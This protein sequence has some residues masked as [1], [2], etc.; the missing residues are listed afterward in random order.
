M[1]SVVISDNE[2]RQRLAEWIEKQMVRASKDAPLK[3]FRLVSSYSGKEGSDVE[4]YPVE[5]GD[6]DVSELAADMLTA[7]RQD[8]ESNGGGAHTYYV[9]PYFGSDSNSRTRHAI[10]VNTP[11]VDADDGDRVFDG[12]NAGKSVLEQSFQH[13][14]R[15]EAMAIASQGAAMQSMTRMIERMQYELE[16]Q[17][18]RSISL[19]RAFTETIDEKERRET[20]RRAIE[21]QE[22]LR[23]AAIDKVMGLLPV[24]AAKL[25]GL[26]LADGKPAGHAEAQSALVAELLGSI[27]PEQ[28]GALQSVL[29]PNQ[30]MTIMQLAEMAKQAEVSAQQSAAASSAGSLLQIAPP[31]AT[32]TPSPK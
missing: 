4:S 24:V 10:L 5:E 27:Q 19:I 18:E 13:L 30:Q 1:N 17:Q 21:S 8:A 28:M 12:R 15:R 25:T 14:E 29:T 16:G 3:F 22:K 31:P 26:P 7:A 6:V 2:R 9:K 20:E 23:M 32:V 11:R